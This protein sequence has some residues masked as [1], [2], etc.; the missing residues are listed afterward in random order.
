MFEVFSFLQKG[1]K[2]LNEEEKRIGRMNS[3][4][5]TITDFAMYFK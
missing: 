1:I 2:V 3:M 4:A 5:I